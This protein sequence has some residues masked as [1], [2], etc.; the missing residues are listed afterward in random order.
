MKSTIYLIRHGLTEGNLRHWFY[1]DSDLP[2]TLEGRDGILALKAD[3]IYPV[4]PENAGCYV[5]GMKRATETFQTIYGGRSFNVIPELREMN[6]GIGEMKTYDEI[7]ILPGAK[8]WAYDEVGDKRLEGGESRLEFAGRVRRG[9]NRLLE[10]HNE[11]APDENG[12][13]VSLLVG[14]GGSI[15][16][17]MLTLFGSTGSSFWAWT[18][19]PG[20]GYALQLD[21]GKAKTYRYIGNWKDDTPDQDGFRY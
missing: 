11:N 12:E 4:I 8:D 16:Q 17:I 5:T 20:M 2:L 6:F 18:P 15:S 3:G 9:W 13:K 14:H 7:R 19:A 21:N 1:G 10:L